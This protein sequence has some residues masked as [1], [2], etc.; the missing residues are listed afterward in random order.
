MKLEIRPQA[1]EA[2]PKLETVARLFLKTRSNGEVDVMADT[3]RKGLPWH[4][5]TINPNGTCY[6][7][8][9]TSTMIEEGFQKDDG[10]HLKNVKY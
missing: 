8:A 4:L 5:V 9:V 2:A 6:L 7:H 3:G 1:G 10:G